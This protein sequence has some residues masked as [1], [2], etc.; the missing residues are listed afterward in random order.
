MWVGKRLSFAAH[1]AYLRERTQARLNV[2]RAMTRLTEG[3]TYSVLRLY[4]VQAVRS[5]VDHSAPALTAL[6]PDQQGRLEV[7]QN[8]AMRTML[9]TPRWT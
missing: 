8:T 3:A 9:G 1:A 5:L 6:S 4:Y 7:L 2:M